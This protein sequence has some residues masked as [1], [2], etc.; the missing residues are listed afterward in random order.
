MKQIIYQA[1]PRL[2]GKG[3]FS[4]WTGKAFSYLKTLGVDY[5]WLTGVPRHE[6][7][8]PF[9]K[10]CPGSPYAIIDWYDVNPYLADN[11]DKRM[12]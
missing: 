10:G 11:E 3:H 7:G 5:L 8:T 4:D 2:W 1:L 12:H 6:S 9:T